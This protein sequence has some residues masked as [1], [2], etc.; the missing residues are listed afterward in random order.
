MYIDYF[1]FSEKPF[2]VTPDP[3]FV[4]LSENHHE[5]LAAMLYGI[6][7]K[8]GFLSVIGEVGTGKTTLL[9]CLFDRLDKSTITVLIFNTIVTFEQLL[10]NILWDF[11]SWKSAAKS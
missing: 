11:A 3:K 4:F 10:K 5:A 8:K 9:R 7:Q 6:N 1:G 2:N